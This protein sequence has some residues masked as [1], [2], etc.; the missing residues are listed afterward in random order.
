MSAHQFNSVLPGATTL[1]DLYTVPAVKRA[2]LRV[3]GTN[4]GAATL[5]RISVAPGGAADT[6]SQ[7]LIYNLSLEANDAVATAPLML[8]AGDVVR[9]YSSSGNVAFHCTGLIQDA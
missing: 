3:V 2:T 8:A 4:R 1:T 9:V 6:A 7:Y 5:I